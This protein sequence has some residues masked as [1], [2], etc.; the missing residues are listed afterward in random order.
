MMIKNICVVIPTIREEHI[1]VFLRKWQN[2][3][4]NCS[5]IIIEDN[6][7]KTFSLPNWVKHYSWEDI[8][9]ELKSDGWIIP[10]RSPAIRSF[11]FLKSIQQGAEIIVT[12]DDDCLPEKGIKGNFIDNIVQNLNKEW[13]DD[14]WWTTLRGE[15]LFPRGYPYLIRNKKQRTVAHHGLWS[16]I[17]DLDGRTQKNNPDFRTK[18][19]RKTEKVPR[20]QYFPMS[21]MNL[22]F[23]KEVVTLFYMLLMGEDNNGNRW[24]YDRF[25]DIWAGIFSK[26]ICDH[27]GLAISSGYPSVSHARASDVDE[28]I[29]KERRGIEDNEWLWEY[30]DKLNLLSDNPADCYIEIAKHI[31]KKRGYWGKLANAMVLW[32]G[33]IKYY[34]KRQNNPV[35]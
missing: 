1:K 28:N 33:Y 9:K 17:P 21:S 15:S 25:D 4:S 16:N 26:K 3:F 18:A 29:R 13:N 30:V 12:L 32:V 20:G 24:G 8:E 2:H 22:A 34:E 5:V 27:L 11:G 35:T 19:F 14:R 23:K 10:R 31:K 6:P 7:E